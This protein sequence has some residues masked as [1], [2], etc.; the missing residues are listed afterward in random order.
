MTTPIFLAGCRGD[1]VT[2]VEVQTIISA[3]VGLVVAI[4]A[5]ITYLTK[6]QVV[7]VKHQTD[8][9]N[10]ALT[11][12]VE[13]LH[14]ALLVKAETSPALPPPTGPAPVALPGPPQH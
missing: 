4:S 7:E 1:A 6:Q 13:E 12:K 2:P 14:A 3:V 8:G 9:Q 10:T 11:A 5:Y